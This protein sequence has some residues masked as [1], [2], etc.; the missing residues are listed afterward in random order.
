MQRS[1]TYIIGV[2]LLIAIGVGNFVASRHFVRV[3][4]TAGRDYTLAPA[5]K[6]LLKGLDDLVTI[7]VYF[8]RNLPPALF[9]L[10]QAVAD[11]LAEYQS[12]AG[13]RIRIEY[14]DPEA[15]PQA[16]QEVQILGIRPAQ[17]NVVAKDKREVARVYLGLA[18]F[19]GDTKHVIP[20]VDRAETLE[21]ELTTGILKVTE[22]KPPTI[23]WWGP[24]PNPRVQ[25]AP[26]AAPQYATIY[27]RLRQRYTVRPIAADGSDL[28]A[29]EVKTLVIV[30]PKGWTAVQQA[31]VERY[32]ASGGRVVALIDRMVVEPT[33]LEATP[34]QSGLEPL[35]AKYGVTLNADLVA[36]VAN[37][38]AAFGD[39]TQTF[40]QPYPFWLVLHR[41]H[42]DA[43]HPITAKLERLTLPWVSS[44]AL[45]ESLP[46]GLTATVLVRSSTRSGVTP[47]EG[48]LRVD[49]ASGVALVPAVPGTVRPLAVL[50]R[51]TFG[52]GAEGGQLLVLG[53]SRIVEDRSAQQF[54]DGIVFFEN[55]VDYFGLGEQLIGIRSR[56]VS[57]RPI[58]ELTD[59]GRTLV[60]LTNTFGMP[61]LVVAGGLFGVAWRRA[62]RRTL[63]AV[64]A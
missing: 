7:R 36:D 51:G 47:S 62:K 28:A 6:Q 42:F 41:D 59:G 60:K 22:E 45:A 38:Y 58:G 46:E 19:H 17:L 14:P 32:L 39:A 21:Y 64:Y 35:L 12:Y 54:G 16:E 63:R 9:P 29:A 24:S 4:L 56:T 27:Q 50:L 20:I 33:T 61:L 10:R 23:G 1:A 48:P 40:I 37:T 31:A 57:A 44:L 13:K 11:T 25:A 5:T 34:V 2:T 55:A 15:S 8:T 3:D 26:S 49:P 43:T 18:L 52:A 53:T 30:A